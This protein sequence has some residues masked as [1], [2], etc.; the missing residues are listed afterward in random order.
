MLEVRNVAKT[1]WVWA[2]VFSFCLVYFWE[3]LGKGGRGVMGSDGEWGCGVGRVKVG[4]RSLQ[5][6]FGAGPRPTRAPG[7]GAG[8]AAESDAEVELVLTSRRLSMA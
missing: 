2:F 8:V 7:A 1:K 6:V 5:Y 3:G 4:N